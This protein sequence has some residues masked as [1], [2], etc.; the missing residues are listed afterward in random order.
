[1]KSRILIALL[2]LF[3]AAVLAQDEW[4]AIEVPEIQQWGAGFACGLQ[5]DAVLF[6]MQ[7]VDQNYISD[8]PTMSGNTY[9]VELAKGNTWMQYP[10]APR[11]IPMGFRGIY[12]FGVISSKND[13]LITFALSDPAGFFEQG[14][15]VTA[16]YYNNRIDNVKEVYSPPAGFLCIHPAMNTAGDQIVFASDKPGGIGGFDL[17][18]VNL[19]EV[20]W[21][22]PVSL[23]PSVNTP[24]NEV[25]PS[26][27]GKNLYFSSTGHVGVGAL[28]VYA[29]SPTN[30]WKQVVPMPAPFNTMQDDFLPLWLSEDVCL[31]N[32]DRSGVDAVYRLTRSREESE[33]LMGYTALLDCKGTGVAGA[34]VTITNALDEDVISDST[35]ASGRFDIGTLLLNQSYKATFD[36]VP[37][38]VLRSSLLYIMDDLGNRIM[39]FVPG[40]DGTFTFELLDVDDEGGLDMMEAIDESSLLNVQVEGQVYQEKPGD[41]ESGEPIYIM[42]E[43]GEV[44]ALA[45]TTDKGKFRF[46]ELTPNA[47]YSFRLDE[48]SEAL[49]MVIFDGDEEIVIPVEEGSAIYERVSE[50]EKVNLKN[51]D[52]EAITIRHDDLFVIQNIYYQLNSAKLNAVARY[53]LDQ[54]AE[55]MVR[56]PEITIELGSHTDSRGEDAYNMELSNRRAQSC[57]DYLLANGVVK[58][59]MKAKGYGESVLLNDCGNDEECSEEE[60]ALN[61]RTE[62]KI[63]VQR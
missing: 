56:N 59:R 40:V 15:I 26:W 53:Q 32:S 55:I 22:E 48:D 10:H 58:D 13:S 57:F 24:G 36:E 42:D 5:S 20:G 3:S 11:G 8:A 47:R 37:M 29:T 38:E 33:S 35:D 28:D 6:R 52:G 27:Q 43:N 23:G 49:N 21:S 9:C 50:G 7:S 25:F 54:L 46:N 31:L 16:T 17:Y 63:I 60:H 4:K 39:V 41:I 14:A 30:Q 19:L 18:Y 2:C 51:E 61:R 62:I 44:M 34:K 12:D 45:Y 1:M